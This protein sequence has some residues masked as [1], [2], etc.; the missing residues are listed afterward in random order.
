M[1]VSVVMATYNGEK[2][3]EQQIQSILNQ[4]IKPDEIIVCDDRSTDGTTDLLERYHNAGYLKYY[5]NDSRLGFVNNFK[6]AMGMATP[7]NHVALADQDDEWLPEKLE[8]SITL[9]K[10]IESDELP[11]MVYSDLIL[12]DQTGQVLNQSFR[13]EF[14]Q[15]RYRHNLETLLFVNFVTGC[16][17]VM[18]PKL[19]DLFMETP[20][21][22]RY[23]DEWLAL[24]AFTFGR[25]K[26]ANTPLVKY[27][28]HQ[29]NASLDAGA[30]SNNRYHSVLSQLLK[31]I[32]GKDDFLSDQ[33]IIISKFYDNYKDKM[34]IENKRYF[35]KFLLLENKTYFAKK[36]A[37]RQM[38]RMYKV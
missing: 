31:A 23:H 7:G 26:S 9:L 13:S 15:D 30:K 4:T 3:L 16:T 5:V 18:N 36:L 24:L 33:F 32:N 10:E 19:R 38:V 22:V 21:D 25:A 37:F 17:V 35:E 34:T 20:D 1:K 8:T 14:G 29:T 28:K 12:T 11:C 2:Y 6:R 27:R